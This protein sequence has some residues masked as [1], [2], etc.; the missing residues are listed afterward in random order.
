MWNCCGPHLPFLALADRDW[1][2]RAVGIFISD[3]WA[4][5][6]YENYDDGGP[7]WDQAHAV[8]HDIVRAIRQAEKL[9]AMARDYDHAS[10]LYQQHLQGMT[11]LLTELKTEMIKCGITF[12]E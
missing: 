11:R 4:E 5:C 8:F 7:E 3:F 2:G 1:T 9:I 6:L 10:R 12:A